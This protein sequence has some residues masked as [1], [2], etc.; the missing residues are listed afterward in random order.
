MKR[1]VVLHGP[2]TLIV[3]LPSKWAKKYGI[4]RGDELD[5]EENNDKLLIN[6]KKRVKLDKKEI[7]ISELYPLIRRT[8]VKV[9]QE[10]YDEI[11]INFDKPEL[12]NQVQS[13][14]GELIGFE[15]IEQGKNR[16]IVK[17][18]SGSSGEDFEVLFRRIFLI[19]KSIFE[20]GQVAFEKNDKALIKNLIYRDIEVNKLTHF[21][22][23]VLNK[24]IVDKKAIYFTIIH[25]CERISDEYKHMLSMYSDKKLK[26]DDKFLKFH[27]KLKQFFDSIYGFTFECKRENAIGIAKY[28]ERLREDIQ[29]VKDY[30][31]FKNLLDNMLFIQ[32]LQLAEIKDI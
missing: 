18:V 26:V 11:A 32:E 12:I 9:Y 15:I 28:N 8:L 30:F 29:S 5:V 3:S 21:C 4:K 2:S 22:L 31:P 14:I 1:K 6:A 27:D 7:N 13:I 20:D 16:C 24:K 10:G 17:N 25:S 19:L 23:R